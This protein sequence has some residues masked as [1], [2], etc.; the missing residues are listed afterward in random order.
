MS[1]SYVCPQAY[2]F[3]FPFEQSCKATCK[4]P[5]MDDLMESDKDVK[6]RLDSAPDEACR[7]HLP[8][9]VSSCAIHPSM[10]QEAALADEEG[11]D[12]Q[13]SNGSAAF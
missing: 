12:E 8:L 4:S 9:N 5:H 1:I 10:L 13:H 6:L 7:P 11:T 2:S 3:G